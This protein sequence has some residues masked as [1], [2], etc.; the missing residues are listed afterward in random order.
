MRSDELGNKVKVLLLSVDSPFI[1]GGAELMTEN[2]FTS[3]INNGHRTEKISLPF[4]YSSISNIERAMEFYENYDLDRLDVGSVDRVIYLKFP[5]YYSFSER[6]R[7]WLMHQHRPFYDLWSDHHPFSEK[8]TSIRDSVIKKDTYYFSK[9]EKIFTISK[10]V[11]NRLNK[12]NGISSKPL[13]QPPSNED[14]YHNSDNLPIIFFPSRIEDLKRQELLV[15]SAALVKSNAVFV[16]SGTGGREYYIKELI[17]K[18][19]VGHKILM[20][21]AISDQELIRLYSICRAVF[22]GPF[23]EDYGFVTL[24]AMLSHKPVITCH[25]S[26]GPLEFVDAGVTGSVVA[27]TP[28]AVADAI[29]QMLNEPRLASEWGQNGRCKYDQMGLSWTSIADHLVS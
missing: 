4:S 18:L 2:L 6:G 16:I 5:A 22:F 26:G 7:V 27:P 25:D 9:Y 23:D 24:E 29:E 20:T 13:Y 11:S 19:D 15:R 17:E 1:R 12:Y 10:N 21:G 8:T 14:R 3:L 28:E